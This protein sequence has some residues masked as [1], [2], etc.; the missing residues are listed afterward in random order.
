[1]SR[2]LHAS[3]YLAMMDDLCC[4][5]VYSPCFTALC[6][7]VIWSGKWS[8]HFVRI[9]CTVFSV[10]VSY[11]GPPVTVVGEYRLRTCALPSAAEQVWN[12]SREMISKESCARLGMP[13]EAVEKKYLRAHPVDTVIFFVALPIKRTHRVYLRWYQHLFGDLSIKFSSTEYVESLLGE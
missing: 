6:Y 1:M 8:L 12:S 4:V 5:L 9:G 7:A 2:D 10:L 11:A 13:V 3:V